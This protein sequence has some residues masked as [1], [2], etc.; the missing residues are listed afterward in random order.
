MKS[1]H[2]IAF[3][4]KNIKIEEIGVF[5][6]SEDFE[7]ERLQGLKALDGMQEFMFL[8]TCNRVEFW[9]RT[10][11]ELSNDYVLRILK[12]AYPSLSE[13]NLNRYAQLALVYSHFE[14]VD[15]VLRVASSINSLVVGE[16]EILSQV[17]R[18]FERFNSYGFCEDFLRILLRKTVEIAKRVYTETNIAT[19]PVSVVNLA[20]KKMSDCLKKEDPRVILVGAGRTNLAI[21]RKLNKLGI[22]DIHVFNRTKSKADTLVDTF[23]GTAYPLTELENYSSGF[24]ILVSCTGSESTMIDL[25][26]FNQFRGKD[27]SEKIVIDLAVPND[28]DR[29]IETQ[30]NVHFISV[31]KLEEIAAKN[32]ESRKGEVEKCEVII[33]DGLAEFES[34]Y[35]VRRVE[36]AMRKVPQQV[37]DIRKRATEVVFADEISNLD[38]EA[39]ETLNKVI[40]FMEKKY[41]STPMLL[42][43]EILLQEKS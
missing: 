1:F 40:S 41:M 22:T 38:P 17:R 7:K 39:V 36:L 30:P 3:T 23:G 29:N 9:F 43:K 10:D 28:I 21:A 25:N 11:E 8:S 24:D 4:H 32:L 42:A 33:N 20:L 18:S 5:H 26:L 35:K 6:I 31:S 37:K 13:E 19:K 12:I 27:N 14:A 2:C 34:V 16:R 15:H